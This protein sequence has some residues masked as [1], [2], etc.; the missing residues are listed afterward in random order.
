MEDLIARTI[1]GNDNKSNDDANVDDDDGDN[2]DDDDEVDDDDYD[3][4]DGDDDISDAWSG[5]ALIFFQNLFRPYFHA[6][7]LICS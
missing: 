3:D 1:N 7:Y 5:T 4:G 6:P 2:D